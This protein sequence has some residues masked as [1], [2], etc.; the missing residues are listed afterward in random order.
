M[1]RFALTVA[2]VVCLLPVVRAEDWKKFES[3]DGCFSVQ[4]PGTPTLK[5]EKVPT[6]VG[7]VELHAYTSELADDGGAVFVAYMEL[8]KEVLGSFDVKAGLEGGVNG[9][10]NGANGKVKSKTWIKLGDHTGIDADIELLGGLA[11]AR[12]RAYFAN[13]KMYQV[14]VI[15]PILKIDNST[16]SKVFDSFE[17]TS[18]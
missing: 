1:K 14:M 6:V 12:Y 16:V 18:N 9:A 11:M 5:T 17:V 10:A 2:A 4:M 13:G 8:P 7:D 15:M 3:R